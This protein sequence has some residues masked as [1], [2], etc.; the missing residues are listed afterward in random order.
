MSKSANINKMNETELEK[1]ISGTIGSWH[2]HYVESPTIYI[3]GLAT[4]HTEK[5]I[6]S[7][8][9]Q[10]GTLTHVNLVRD[11]HT[12]QSKQFAFANYA[13]AR[14]AVLAVDNL[15]AFQL[16]GSILSVD[17]VDDYRVPNPPEAFDTTPVLTP[18]SDTHGG[19][20]T[21]DSNANAPAFTNVPRPAIVQI[22]A[23]RK[24]ELSVMARMEKFRKRR[25]IETITSD[26]QLP[27]ASSPPSSRTQQV[28]SQRNNEGNA[29]NQNETAFISTLNPQAET[30][31]QDAQRQHRVGRERRRAHRA[32]IRQARSERR[33]QR[34]R[35][36]R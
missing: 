5:H 31:T 2:Q 6:L 25:R 36:S 30:V 32:A 34:D 22:E 33:M 23:D 16:D 8:F 13:D 9:E 24:R 28:V 21:D 15:N 4:T 26:D 7:I 10:Y 19:T 1:G 35:Q 12:K 18:M 11:A 14:S 27:I 20:P 29:H 17:H 3:G